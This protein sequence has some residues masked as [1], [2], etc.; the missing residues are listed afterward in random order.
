MRPQ[1][2]HH[3]PLLPLGGE[4]EPRAH[5]RPKRRRLHQRP[6]AS[7]ILVE[8]LDLVDDYARR[9]GRRGEQR[10]EGAEA[11]A[12]DNEG[13]ELPAAVRRVAGRNLVRLRAAQR[14]PVNI[15]LRRLR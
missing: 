10:R 1:R 14:A 9:L 8:E 11:A 6:D 3:R 12:R 13:F 5:D 2:R 15:R 7:G 4:V